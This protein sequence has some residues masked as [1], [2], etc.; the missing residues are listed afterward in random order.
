MPTLTLEYQ[1]IKK[2]SSYMDDQRAT[3][4]SPATSAASMHVN[5][6]VVMAEEGGGPGLMHA[7]GMKHLIQTMH[8]WPRSL[9]LV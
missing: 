1:Y 4:L 2:K 9:L 6:Q 3:N 7:T 8:R 5:K